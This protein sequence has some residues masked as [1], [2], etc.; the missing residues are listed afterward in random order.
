LSRILGIFRTSKTSKVLS[1]IFRA[2]SST[3]LKEI[4]ILLIFRYLNILILLDNISLYRIL[5]IIS[6]KDIVINKGRGIS[7]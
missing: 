3:S 4:Y 7:K 6:Y 5:L 2:L 1:R